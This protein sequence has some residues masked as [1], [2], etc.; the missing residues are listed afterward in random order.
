MA[1]LPWI[2]GGAVIADFLVWL[3]IGAPM[4]WNAL[5]AFGAG[6]FAAL[7]TAPDKAPS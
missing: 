4:S 1:R 2:V 3:A 5:F 6:A 7:I